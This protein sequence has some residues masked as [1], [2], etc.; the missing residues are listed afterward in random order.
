MR[1]EHHGPMRNPEI[2]L[3]EDDDEWGVLLD[4]DTGSTFGLSPVGLFIWTRLDGQHTVAD[5]LRELQENVGDL[6]DE[7]PSEVSAF[8]DQL[9][10]RGLVQFVSTLPGR[11]A[12]Y[13]D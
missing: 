10:Q 7:A 11:V 6:P 4:P 2:V 12:S 5:I 9:A 1:T 13:E 8:V 3:R